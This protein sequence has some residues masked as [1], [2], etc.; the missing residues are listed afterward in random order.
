MKYLNYLNFSMIMIALIITSCSTSSSK[1]EERNELE[2]FLSISDIHFNPFYDSTLTKQLVATD[3]SSWDLIFATSKQEGYG[4]YGWSGAFYDTGYK[5][6]KSALEE[7]KS[8][9]PDPQFITIN[10]D[11]LAHSFESNFFNYAQISD[12]AALHNF[13]IKTFNYIVNAIETT[14][15]NATLF[16]TLGN[17]DSFCGDYEIETPGSFLTRTASIWQEHL[18]G[19]IDVQDFNTT[20]KKGG[21][22]SAKSPVNPKH[23]IISL[24]TVML[25]VKYMK[26]QNFCGQT[27]DTVKNKANAKAQFDWLEAELKKAQINN[28]KVW[29]MY[30]IPPGMNAYSSYSDSK[31]DRHNPMGAPY[32]GS[33]Y[34]ETYLE[35][36]K[37][38]QPIITAQLG[39]HSHMDNFIVINGDRVPQSFVHISPAIS[40]VYQ[41]NPGFLEYKF[42]PKSTIMKDY[43]VHGFQDVSTAKTANW[44]KEYTY[45]T[46]YNQ[47]SLT[48]MAL[49]SVYQ[50]FMADPEAKKR[51]IDYYVVEDTVNSSIDDNNWPFYFCAFGNQSKED[52]EN[53][54]KKSQWVPVK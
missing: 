39:G 2:Q 14:F 5:L 30:H 27:I 28:E 34:N 23:K 52:Y 20:Y 10:G 48:P 17:N 47:K 45:S 11:F 29:L 3:A 33:D 9:N 19:L 42:N 53:C 18:K 35:L 6:F 49:Q 7:M 43:D 37:K 32:Y 26:N 40:P 24:N 8:V 22:Y 16:P 44:S 51:Y 25:S 4:Y 12:T 15:P 50:N 41:N 1:I 54:V 21:Y 13:T 38:Y 46:T 36:I 31:A